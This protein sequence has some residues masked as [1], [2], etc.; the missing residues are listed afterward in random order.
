[1][2]ASAMPSRAGLTPNT[3][4]VINCS[5]ISKVYIVPARLQQ[6][7]GNFRQKFL[8]ISEFTILMLC[9]CFLYWNMIGVQQRPP[10]RLL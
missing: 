1:M 2:G 8:N 5:F 7:S 3:L 6:L 9:V 10:G 4:S